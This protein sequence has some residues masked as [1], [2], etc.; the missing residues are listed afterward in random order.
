MRS[1]LCPSILMTKTVPTVRTV[2]T[3]NRIRLLWTIPA[4]TYITCYD[5]AHYTVFLLW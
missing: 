3:A 5:D 1:L 2:P 4:R